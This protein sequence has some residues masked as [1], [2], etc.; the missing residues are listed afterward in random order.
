MCELKT[1]EFVS[2]VWSFHNQL[3]II[4]ITQVIIFFFNFWHYHPCILQYFSEMFF[5]TLGLRSLMFL[6]NIH[7]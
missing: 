2:S 4:C 1:P 6:P 7:T 3:V 5:L